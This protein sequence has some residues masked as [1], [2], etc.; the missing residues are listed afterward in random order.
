MKRAIIIILVIVFALLV[1]IH[2]YRHRHFRDPLASK[3]NTTCKI[4]FNRQALGGNPSNIV[5]V[6]TDN[7]NGARV[8]LVGTLKQVTRTWLVIEAPME[9]DYKKTQTLWIPRN[10]VMCVSTDVNQY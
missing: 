6:L 8:S 7:I 1:A 4:Y 3:I 10:V 2:G 9:P 5:P